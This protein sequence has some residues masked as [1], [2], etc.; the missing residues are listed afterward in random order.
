MSE[1]GRL[2]ISDLTPGE[3]EAERPDEASP[4]TLGANGGGLAPDNSSAARR[5]EAS[6]GANGAVEAAGELA[7]VEVS[8]LNMG[9][10]PTSG[11]GGGLSP[12]NSSAA[13]RD[14]A[15]PDTLGANGGGL[16]PDNSS[17]VR[18]DEVSPGANGAVEAAG[19]FASVEVSILNEVKTANDGEAEERGRQSIIT[20]QIMTDSVRTR[21][22]LKQGI[23]ATGV[24]FAAIASAR[25]GECRCLPIAGIFVP[26]HIAQKA[27][28]T[29]RCDCKRKAP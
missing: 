6:P 11:N 14:E 12:D 29:L 9:R 22:K 5:D 21:R 1:A 19:E 4:D 17:A 18:R 26:M 16:A 15:S 3:V 10:L 8:I 13:R 2:P 28:K 24:K 27:E 23:A 25:V 20:L 7:S